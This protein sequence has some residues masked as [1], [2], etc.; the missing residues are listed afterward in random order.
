M[1]TSPARQAGAEATHRLRAVDHVEADAGAHVGDRPRQPVVGHQRRARGGEQ[2]PR[3]RGSEL[4]AADVHAR[5]EHPTARRDDAVGVVD[6]IQL[7]GGEELLGSP[8]R[9]QQVGRAMRFVDDLAAH[10]AA[11]GPV[12]HWATE[13]VGE[14]RREH[15]SLGRTQ[16]PLDVTA[17]GG[18][19]LGETG[20]A[21]RSGPHGDVDDACE[22]VSSDRAAT[23]RRVGPR[24]A[25]GSEPQTVH[26]W[27]W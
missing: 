10:A 6:P 16:C 23:E 13:G 11:H 17:G 22:H 20:R 26:G 1:S 18:R 9:P 7:D 19:R 27:R 5:E 12:V 21:A 8:E 3:Q 15:A 2:H 25:V 14:V 24:Q 4:P